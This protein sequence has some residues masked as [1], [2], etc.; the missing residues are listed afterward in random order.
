M[1]QILGHRLPAL[2]FA[3]RG[4]VR[5][6]GLSLLVVV[7]LGFGLGATTAVVD[8]VNLLVWRPL[9]VERADEVVKVYTAPADAWAPYL[10]TGYPDYLHYRDGAKSFEG[11]AALHGFEVR[12][13]RDGSGALDGPLEG[14]APRR[15]VAVS[16]EFFSVLG[17]RPARGRLFAPEDDRPGADPVAVLSHRAWVRGGADPDVVGSEIV[18]EG[19]PFTV[20]GVGPPSFASTVAGLVDDVYLPLAAAPLVA[21]GGEELL[22]ARDRG[23]FAILG[24]LG[25]G[26]SRQTA[27][28]ELDVLAR[29]LDAAHPLDNDRSRRITV[30]PAHLAHPLD[31]VRM[32]PTLRL[33]AGAVAVLLLITCANVALLLLAR[34]AER[35]REMALRLSLGAG[36]GA[37]LRQMLG[38][39]LLLA[40]AGGGLGLVVARAARYF[41]H[42]FAGPE[43]AA[44]MRFDHRVLGVA[45]LAALVVTLVFGLAPAWSATRVDPARALK[46]SPRAGRGLAR[47]RGLL[48]AAQVALAVVLLSTGLLFAENLRR[49]LGAD[50]GFD[51]DGLWM[52]HVDLSRVG[53]AEERARLE[54]RW[55][56]RVEALPGVESAALASRVPP[57]FFDVETPVRLPDR[58]DPVASTRTNIVSPEF[59]PTLGVEL[60]RGR[61]FT[62]ADGP[63]SR[64]VVV[65]NER[66]AEALWP[67][68]EAVGRVVRMRGR[69][70]DPGPEYTVIGVVESVSQH[71]ARPGGE[72][73]LYY[74][75]TQRPRPFRQLVVRSDLA[76]EA[77]TD[78]VRRELQEID[79]DLVMTGAMTGAEHR[80]VAFVFERMQTQAVGVFAVLGFFL[81]AVGIFG[82]LRHAV[83]LRVREIGVRKALGARRADVRRQV[84]GEGV[85]L[86]AAGCVAGL[87]VVLAG[88]RLLESFLYGVDPGSPWVLAA[89]SAAVLFAAVA[90]SW[91]PA[92]RAARLEPAEALRHE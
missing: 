42:T 45:L 55:R 67:G 20:V 85:R 9:P 28:A 46:E 13:G 25:P 92:R 43:L 51:E 89:V 90:A 59:F 37:L 29:G 1:F 91:L 24:R 49:H 72:A 26:Q 2:R 8:L 87:A 47:G 5:R 63:E 12:V 66:L 32:L 34:S 86:A 81:A 36:R 82:L 58:E 68:E 48:V 57:F 6:P 62:A 38:E 61:L 71:R 74:A 22:S 30:T 39:S 16:G 7:L 76:P 77:L 11:L 19:Q 70:H 88:G 78:A 84:V 44:E 35:R 80:R 41:L 15:A 83:S 17:L 33:F 23:T 79:A 3:L 50:M 73:I 75:A 18:L 65:V 52:A 27:A 14:V 31:R 69:P 56:G 21:S 10:R 60:R 40:L 53:S 4:V 64:P 54:E